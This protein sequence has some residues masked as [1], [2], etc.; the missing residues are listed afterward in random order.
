M[1]DLERESP[2]LGLTMTIDADWHEIKPSGK[3][4]ERRSYHKGILID[5][6]YYIFGGQDLKEGQYNNIWKVNVK[7]LLKS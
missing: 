7:S 4:P 3:L 6:T 5:D 1:D 2:S